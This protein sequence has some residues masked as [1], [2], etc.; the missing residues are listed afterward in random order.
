MIYSHIPCESHLD[1]LNNF[2]GFITNLN[3]SQL[4]QFSIFTTISLLTDPDIKI[5]SA[6][7]TYNFPTTAYFAHNFPLKVRKSKLRQITTKK[8]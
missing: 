8:A 6:E 2:V 5:C 3:F 7:K 1:M 4:T